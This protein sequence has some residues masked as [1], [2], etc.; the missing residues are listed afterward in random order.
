M[1]WTEILNRPEGRIIIALALIASA[2]SLR[3][4]QSEWARD[5]FV[6]GMALL[7]RDMG[8]RDGFDGATHPRDRKDASEA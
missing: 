3:T 1:R 8:V 7:A 4:V 6:F 2:F 5:M